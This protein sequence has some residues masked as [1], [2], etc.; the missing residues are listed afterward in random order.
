M[1]NYILPFFGSGMYLCVIL[2]CVLA[3]HGTPSNQCSTQDG[4]NE[5]MAF[6]A[7][8]LGWCF[9]L[10]RRPAPRTRQRSA[11]AKAELKCLVFDC[12]GVIL[13]S[14]DLHRRAY[15]AAFENFSVKCKDKQVVWDEEF[16][17]I[18]QNTGTSPS[19]TAQTCS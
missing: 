14:E 7:R 1:K 15:N 18:L 17:D 6:D 2:R 19:L 9:Y 16:Y 12:D 13:E 3:R 10:C 4:T 5:Q 11:A 8:V